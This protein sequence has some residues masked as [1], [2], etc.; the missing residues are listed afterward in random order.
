MLKNNKLC[1]VLIVMFGVMFFLFSCGRVVEDGTS[2]GGGG[3]GTSTIFGTVRDAATNATLAGVAVSIVGGGNTTTDGF[4]NFKLTNTPIGNKVTVK[5]FLTGYAYGQQNLMVSSSL[6][7][8]GSTY[9]KTIGASGEFDSN[10]VIN[11]SEAGGASVNI[12][13]ESLDYSGQVKVELTSFDPTI[14]A[15]LSAFPGGFVS[16]MGGVDSPIETFGFVNINI[17][18]VSDGSSV[19]LASGKTIYE[20]KIPAAPGSPATCPLFYFDSVDSTWKEIGT[21]TLQG[22]YY[23]A[24]D[25]SHTSYWNADQNYVT[26][27]ITGKVLCEENGQPIA[28]AQI[29]SVGVDYSG[30]QPALTDQNG[31]FKVAAKSNSTAYVRITAAN[32]TKTSQQISTGAT[33]SETPAGTFSL[34]NSAGNFSNKDLSADFSPTILPTGLD[35][36]FSNGKLIFTLPT[37]NEVK[38]ATWDGTNWVSSILDPNFSANPIIKITSD[39]K[40]KVCFIRLSDNCLYYAYLAGSNWIVQKILNLNYTDNLAYSM[41]LENDKPHIF[42]SVD[43]SGQTV[44]DIKELYSEDEAAWNTREVRA[45][46]DFPISSISAATK[47]DGTPGLV[48]LIEDSSGIIMHYYFMSYNTS[49]STWEAPVE[50]GNYSLIGFSLV[51]ALLQYNSAGEPLI[52]VRNSPGMTNNILLYRLNGSIW[53]SSVVDSAQNITDLYDGAFDFILNQSD[54]PIIL[55]NKTDASASPPSPVLKLATYTGSA[56]DISIVDFRGSAQG[57]ITIGSDNKVHVFYSSHES[58]YYFYLSDQMQ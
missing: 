13:G 9:L 22:N 39:G 38:Y 15:E 52:A 5:Y 31:N 44:W 46:F 12:S 3:G 49:G 26:A 37:T 51:A 55:F 45:A 48:Y 36:A 1:F 24:N 25:V 33:N 42:Y 58:P 18:K 54:N 40:P 47:P 29:K 21:L 56:W 43:E 20:I 35:I 19:D 30:E 50:V 7:V 11:L 34:P 23:I 57:K 4:G 28:G 2:G 53:Q 6:P 10:N 14:P 17:T 16:T 41:V 27:F 8:D 32:S